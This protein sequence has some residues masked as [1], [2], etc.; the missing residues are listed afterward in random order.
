MY[1]EAEQ[2]PE[3]FDEFDLCVRRKGEATDVFLVDSSSLRIFPPALY[4]LGRTQEALGSPDAAH[5]R[6]RQ[7]LALR[8][9]ADPA[10]PLAVDA[11]ARLGEG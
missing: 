11:R 9:D 3:A 2:F 1:M 7:F 8:G 5:E 10:D 4:W 6:Y